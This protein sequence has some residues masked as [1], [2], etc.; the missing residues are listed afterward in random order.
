MRPRRPRPGAQRRR[1]QPR[2]FFALNK[3]YLVLC[4]FRDR[5]GR[6]TLA[7]Y[8]DVPHVYAIG[9]LDYDSEGLLLLTGHGALAHAIASPQRAVEKRYLAQLE[10]EITKE[11]LAALREGVS[12]K[13][14]PTAPAKARR[15]AEPTLWPRDP[16]IRE[17]KNSPTSWLELTITE[18]RNRQVRRMTAAV[19][20][21]TLRLIRQAI[22]PWALGELQPG[23]VRELPFPEDWVTSAAAK[24]APK[25]VTPRAQ[26]GARP[27]SAR[28]KRRGESS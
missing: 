20:F 18:G 5:D 2:R 16:P 12:L 21:P 28:R 22:G 11:A 13:D 1:P 14:G 10:G 24:A 6:K 3:P 27:R 26:P 19:G 25:A 7:D 23:E 9:R 4:Q 17:R 8:V 15:V